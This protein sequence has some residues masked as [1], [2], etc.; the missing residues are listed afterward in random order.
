MP[1]K[2]DM[3]RAWD[4][5][6]AAYQSRRVG[7]DAVVRYGALAPDDRVLG[8]LGDVT[9]RNVLDLGCGGGQASTALAQ[10]GAHVTGLDVSEQQLAF[11][12]QIAA[13]HGVT[14]NFVHADAAAAPLVLASEFDLILAAHVL[15]YADNLQT[16]LR[17]CHTLLRPRGRLVASIDHP[18]RSCFVD[19][20]D[21]EEV[22]YPCQSYLREHVQRWSFEAG[23]PMQS[24]HL[25]VSA[26]VDAVTR[27]GF[28]LDRMI[29]PP[30]PP[31]LADELWPEDSP[32]AP[33]RMI[34]HTLI[35]IAVKPGN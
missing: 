27:A 33:L 13:S 22:P 5:A 19:R 12:R 14:V 28:R 21:G 30:V 24:H 8:L 9:G 1:R 31:G 11:A 35:I 23:L 25:P 4:A 26:W 6:A 2:F 3:R 20:A 16:T 7:D 29:E 32:L 18:I 10:A 34:P 15:P 17:A